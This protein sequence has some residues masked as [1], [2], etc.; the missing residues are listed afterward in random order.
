MLAAFP[1][2]RDETKDFLL[3][4]V[5]STR[6]VAQEWSA[7]S[8]R[9]GTL[10]A[11]VVDAM[12]SAGLFA[13]KL[14]RELGGA[15]ADPVTQI[16]VIEAMSYID[17]AAGWCLMI[18]ATAIGQPGAFMGDAA[19]ETMF[20]GGHVPLGATVT[21]PSGKATAVDGGYLLS[22]RW[23]FASGV[24]H[25]EWIANG[26]I[27]QPEAAAAAN[28]EGN[29]GDSAAGNAEPKY[30]IMV[31]PASEAT[32]HDNW[33]VSGLSGT[34][35]ND[36]S[37]DGLFVPEEFTWDYSAW[38]AK[39]GGALYR[40]GRPGFVANEHVGFAL[41]VARRALD[42]TMALA[43]SKRRG[44][45]ATSLA[46][47]QAFQRDMGECDLRLRAARLLSHSVFE[48]AFAAAS[49]GR[50]PPAEMQA[51]MRATAS[52]ATAVAVDAATA[53]FRY[54]G[55]SAIFSGN[56]LERCMRDINAAAQHFMV[57][58]SA[59]EQYGAGLLGARDVQ[60]MG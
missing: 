55:A 23:Q 32:I 12:H 41:G 27:L 3:A 50:L 15:E 8:E 46:D 5:E 58:E 18:G 29:A 6:E 30:L 60:P 2:G 48:R 37:V 14:P 59:I 40:M 31:Y 33:H 19:V 36:V 22:G 28:A 26:A 1:T 56:I 7:E 13:L 51:E 24:R 10:A 53:A 17:A 42:E 43:R 25:A 45:P 9:A 49:E 52:Y 44:R 39:R 54:A 57:S 16:E 11:P 4:A 38:R 34:G 21:A 47:R 35:S 20:A